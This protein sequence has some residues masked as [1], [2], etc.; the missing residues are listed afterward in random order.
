MD[1]RRIVAFV[2]LCLG[3][4][5]AY[6]GVYP[7]MTIMS[8]GS[9]LASALFQPPTTIVRL[10]AA[11]LMTFGGVLAVFRIRLGGTIALIG[12]VL[13]T[14]LGALMAASGA[15]QGLWMDEVLF[16]IGAIGV[17]VLIL[18]LRRI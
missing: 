7:L 17:A 12:A 6:D 14:A 11:G 18:T 3:A 15:D 1:F 4:F 8:R 10:I 9:D 16:G 5:L 13:F 2:M